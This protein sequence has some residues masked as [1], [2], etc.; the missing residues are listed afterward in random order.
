MNCFPCFGS[1]NTETNQHEEI[2]V[3]QAKGNPSSQPPGMYM[4]MCT[5]FSYA[6]YLL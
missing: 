3:A 1:K 2:P 5:C 6:I 4:Y